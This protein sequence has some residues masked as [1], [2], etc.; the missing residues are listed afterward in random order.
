MTTVKLKIN[1]DDTPTQN[2]LVY[3]YGDQHKLTLAITP[4]CDRIHLKIRKKL[5]DLLLRMM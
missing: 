2:N 4:H 1:I 5:E 3:S